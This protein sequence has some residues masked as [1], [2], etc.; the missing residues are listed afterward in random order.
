MHRPQALQSMTMCRALVGAPARR[1]LCWLLAAVVVLQAFG[2]FALRAMPR[3]HFHPASSMPAGGS[4][5][6]LN[7]V[8]A[9]AP[10]LGHGH[11]YLAQHAHDAGADAIDVDTSD[12]GSRSVDLQ[13]PLPA[14]ATP[15][16]SRD[17]PPLRPPPGVRFRSRTTLP[18][19][20]PPRG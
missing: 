11:A 16:A 8:L 7:A 20:E 19:D 17:A 9:H 15:V 1:A 4:R 13:V 2:P 18:L 10:G 6:D 5:I 14:V 3:A 12:T